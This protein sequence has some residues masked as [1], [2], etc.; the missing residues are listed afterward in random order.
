MLGCGDAA[1]QCGPPLVK[2][3]Q[4]VVHVD[5]AKLLRAGG[6]IFATSLHQRASASEI[7]GRMMVKGH[8][9]LDKPLQEF[10]FHPFRFAPYVFPDF[11]SVIELTRIEET[12]PA[13]IAISVH[14][15]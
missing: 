8:R 13:V 9:G 2:R 7:A 10:F 14:E 4:Q 15:S 1:S 5:S 12:N 3:L 6:K 11:M